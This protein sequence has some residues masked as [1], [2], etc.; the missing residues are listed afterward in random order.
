M[1]SY[2]KDHCIIQCFLLIGLYK[3]SIMYLTHKRETD[4]MLEDINTIHHNVWYNK[5]KD[6]LIF[7]DPVRA[8]HEKLA[9]GAL[10][11]TA[12]EASNASPCVR[13]RK[14][15]RQA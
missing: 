15:S 8:W 3:N 9:K 11:C 13:A 7:L 4:Y 1:A 2:Q 14:A 5:C 10:A 6:I 12:L